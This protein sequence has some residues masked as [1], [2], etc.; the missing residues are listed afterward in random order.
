MNTTTFKKCRLR[1]T[2]GQDEKVREFFPIGG[3][4]FF[5]YAA[6]LEISAEELQFFI[7]GPEDSEEDDRR[8]DANVVAELEVFDDEGNW[9][10]IKSLEPVK[11]TGPRMDDND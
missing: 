9:R 7:T 1:W 4:P 6:L 5:T 8:V 10:R 2:D 3:R 11:R